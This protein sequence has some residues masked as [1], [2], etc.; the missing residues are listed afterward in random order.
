MFPEKGTDGK[1]IEKSLFQ[2]DSPVINKRK[3]LFSENSENAFRKKKKRAPMTRT[4][5]SLKSEK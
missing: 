5:C 1:T 2:E 3:E 4:L